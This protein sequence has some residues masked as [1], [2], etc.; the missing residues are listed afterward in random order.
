MNS[1]QPAV[2]TVYTFSD[3]L[4]WTFFSAI[5]VL[6][7]VYATARASVAQKYHPGIQAG[8]NSR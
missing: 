1:Q 6:I 3:Y 7:A 8:E 2:K 5:P 4:S